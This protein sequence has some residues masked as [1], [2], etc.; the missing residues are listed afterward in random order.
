[1]ECAINVGNLGNRW[2]ALKRFLFLRDNTLSVPNLRV[3]VP[4]TSILMRSL[5]SASSHFSELDIP[6]K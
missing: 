1:M 5:V 4:S 6:K 3:P 2:A